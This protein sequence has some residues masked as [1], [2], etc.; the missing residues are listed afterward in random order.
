[1]RSGDGRLRQAVRANALWLLPCA[2][3]VLMAWPLLF[4]QLPNFSSTLGEEYQPLKALK[5]L[6]TRGRDVH[7]WGPGDNFIVLPGYGVSLLVWKMR[8]TMGTPSGEFPYGLKDPLWQLTVLI[9]QSRV[10]F[11]LVGVGAMFVLCRRWGRLGY[12]R[13]AV[14]LAAFL[15]L[16]ANPVFIR[17][18]VIL[19]TDLPMMAGAMVGLAVYARIVL[20]GLTA[21]RAGWLGFWVAVA[22]TGKEIAAPLFGLRVVGLLGVVWWRSRGDSARRAVYWRSVASAVVVGVG[23]YVVLN[24][25]Y[26]PASW[27]ARMKIWIG[28]TGMDPA[29]WATPG[30]NGWVA[31]KEIGVM[32]LQNLGYGGA[33]ALLVS[34]GVV[35]WARPRGWVMLMLPLVGFVGLGLRPG[36]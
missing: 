17:H 1:L 15:C 16:A 9:F 7:K 3:V 28:G 13:W 36:G 23:V 6:S 8:G 35:A 5:F 12:A 2:F 34:V 29:V 14:V 33:V 21:R 32:V 20:E 19:K 10:E 4:Y 26:A 30:R 27:V 25:V 18:C 24:I 31:A 22:V 11:L